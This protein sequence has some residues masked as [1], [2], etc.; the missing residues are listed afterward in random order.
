M[1]QIRKDPFKSNYKLLING[2]EKEGIKTS[3]NRKYLL[4][5][6][7]QLMMFIRN[8]KTIIQQRKGEC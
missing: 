8:W 5:I 3:K 2:R 4:I 7:K 6:H 1:I